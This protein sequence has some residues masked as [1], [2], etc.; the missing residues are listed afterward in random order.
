[1]V[2]IW[3]GMS[4]FGTMTDKVYTENINEELYC[5]ILE[6]ELKRF[7]AKFPTKTKMVYQDLAQWQTSNVVKERIAK[8]KLNV[9]D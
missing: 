7:I 2:G 9:F 3:D 8:L 1:M 4:G 6:T 5:Y